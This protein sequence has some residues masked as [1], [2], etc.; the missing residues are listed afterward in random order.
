MSSARASAMTSGVVS[1]SNSFFTRGSAARASRVEIRDELALE[2][3]DL[4]LEDQLALLE[5]LQLQ[6]VGLEVERQARDDLV[7][8]AVRDAEFAQLFHVLEKLAIDVVLIFDF[9][10]RRGSDRRWVTG[11]RPAASLSHRPRGFHGTAGSW[12][13]EPM[14]AS[15]LKR[16]HNDA[17]RSASL[18]LMPAMLASS[19]TPPSC[20]KAAVS[21]R[22][23][24]ADRR[25]RCG[26]ASTAMAPL[27]R[28]TAMAAEN[29]GHSAGTWPALSRFSQR[30]NAS[31][32][33]RACPCSTSRRARCRR[34]G[35][36]ACAARAASS[37]PGRRARFSSRSPISLR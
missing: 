10:H 29:A 8:I 13:S 7:E 2:P 25:Y 12:K 22:N 21:S 28:N 3:S 5:T 4:V 17:M 11:S 19:A 6:L 23:W 35:A 32:V 15:S 24:P 16:R 18:G 31:C 37:R 36:V 1:C 20:T 14:D 27:S 34:V 26:C 33:S 9:A 30:S